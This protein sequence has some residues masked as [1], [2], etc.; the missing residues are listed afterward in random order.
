MRILLLVDAFTGLSQRVWCELRSAGHHVGALFSTEAELPDA[1]RAATPDLV[2]GL[3]V[4]QPIDPG[5]W[6][7]YRTV[8]V[9]PGSADGRAP[10][11]LDAAL[12]R[13]DATWDITAAEAA[14][15]E[16]FR[17]VWASRSVLVASAAARKS[18]IY[19]GP[20]A[21]A[22]TECVLEVVAKAE[23]PSFAAGAEQR[24]ADHARI[25]PLPALAA[26]DREFDW[27]EP[28]AD[29]VRK[30]RA[31]DGSPGVRTRI[32]RQAVIAYDA[33][34]G[35]LPFR[36]TPG[37]LLSRR[38][39]AAQIATGDGSVWIGRLRRI[40]ATGAAGVKLPART[41]LGAPPRHVT[42]ALKERLF[43]GEPMMMGRI[44]DELQEIIYRRTAAVGWLTM[45]F[46][47][48]AMSTEQCRR[49]E[50]A[51][52]H[53]AHQDTR[54]LVLRSTPEVF[55][56][57][58]DLAGIDV[59]RDPWAAAWQNI[60]ALNAVAREILTSTRKV[61][62]AAYAGNASAGGVMFGL[63]A[64]IVAA[65][66]G[67]VLNP[68]YDI[69]LSGS[70]L[71]TVTLR[72]RVGPEQARRL[73]TDKL[74]IT[75]EYG[76]SLGLVDEI[77]PRDPDSFTDWLN[78]LAARYSNRPRVQRM[79]M[80]KLAQHGSAPIP[81][82]VLETRELAQMSHDVFDDRLGFNAAR[83]AFVT[84]APRARTPDRLRLP[85][86]TMIHA[87]GAHLTAA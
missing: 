53:A 30:I 10:L 42:R 54:V 46:Y 81:I 80:L 23:D 28:T 7:G 31:S 18:A 35:P 55:S 74:P 15:S 82:D 51:I 3:L 22:V 6:Q 38:R 49:L 29:I 21:D 62:I 48:G 77:G 59:A 39:T 45:N 69:G 19:R 73:L 44:P 64:D 8:Y 76:A 34:P 14:D 33:H 1:V 17:R 16:G 60:K 66:S 26:A 58:I 56:N 61:V 52:R 11:S 40:S 25:V 87:G 78:D 68:Y 50:L 4:K 9:L 72:R 47:N 41:V 27:S 67:I 79:R 5:A 75:A 70:A 71:H 32:N 13:G 86:R 63:G 12:L 84:K 20:V 85:P 65:R 24:R 43:R 57:G 37:A 83:H 2:V 36:A